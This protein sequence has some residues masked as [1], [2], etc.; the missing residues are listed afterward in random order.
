MSTNLILE[1]LKTELNEPQTN[2]NLK[3]IVGGGYKEFWNNQSRYRLLKGG[4]GS[5]KST[6]MSIWL[7][8]NMMKMYHQY[9]VKP[10]A[11]VLRRYFSHHRQSTYTQL[12]WAI[13]KLGV[14]HLWKDTVN[15]MELTYLP[16]G[17]KII[18]RG[19]DDPISLTSMTVEDGHLCWVWWEEAYQIQNENDF[20]KID[21]SIRGHLPYPLFKQHTFTF[22]PWSENIWLK[23]R[24]FDLT[25]E[26]KLKHSVWTSTKNY[27]CNEFLGKDDFDV[28]RL[29]KETNPRRYSIEGLGEW[30]I[31]DGL[32]FTNWEVK[33]FD[34][35]DKLTHK[36]KYG[37]NKYRLLC[38]L[39][40]G[41]T[42]DPTVFIM[43]LVDEDN[44]EIYVC[45]EIYRTGMLDSEIYSE[46]D[47]LG[48]SNAVIMCDR[49]PRTHANLKKLGLQRLTMAKKGNDSIEA[50]IN[51]L[52]DYKIYFHE[53]NCPNF[54]IEANNYVWA[55]DKNT[56]KFINKPIDD[57]NH[58]W[59]ALRYMAE[60]IGGNNFAFAG[61]RK[62][63]SSARGW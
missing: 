31:A 35:Q 38:G 48:L 7:P 32:I 56:G 6:T 8:Y 53:K 2:I 23:S 45:N 51:K 4:R 59:D 15:P 46:I 39:D 18:F 42:N 55:T 12:K 17:Q 33:D 34:I 3:D 9:G 5:K 22:N 58:A 26:E 24:F 63:Y 27:D 14:S 16:S 11:L 60:L 41:F 44:Y 43:C 54:A 37:K 50:G 21:L 20:D 47:R 29:M 19:L 25:D 10:N 49:D 40:F 36:D 62:P 61:E 52:R 30:G 1:Q 57:F 28:F 13:N